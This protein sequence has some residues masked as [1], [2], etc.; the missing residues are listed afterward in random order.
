MQ[1]EFNKYEGAGNDFIM[2]DNRDGSFPSSNHN[3]IA[4]IC[5][6][7]F[8]IGADG[9]ILLNSNDQFDFEMQ[10]FNADGKLGSMCGNGGRC[11]FMFARS[12]GVVSDDAIFLASDG[13][14]RAKLAGDDIVKLGMR[15]VQKPVSI[16]GNHFINTGS[17]HYI[18]HVSNLDKIDVCSRGRAIRHSE[19][20]APGGSNVNF[21]EI[22]KD[23]I[24]VRTYERG[25][26]DETLSCGTGI[27]A[28]AI[29]SKWQSMDGDHRVKVET[30]G[31]MLEVSF[32]IEGET[33]K[34]IFLTGPARK[35]FTGQIN[36]DNYL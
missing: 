8:G 15:D 32:S 4:A 11:I 20:F 2:I 9:L 14:H 25:V 36:L 21:V 30:R 31:G 24:R 6:R 34:N 23:K 17:P 28:S 27:T 1:K 7:H 35:V 26:E 10:Y 22:H 16:L 12:L 5:N 13:T 29:S 19:H 18:I 3:M 33:A